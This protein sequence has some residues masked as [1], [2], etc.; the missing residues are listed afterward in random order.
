LRRAILLTQGEQDHLFD[1]DWI[2]RTMREPVCARSVMA[3]IFIA[4]EGG[5]QRC[6]SGTNAS[7][8][9]Q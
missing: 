8:D 9:L 2:H 5:E 4:R 1:V 3:R 6:G 7:L